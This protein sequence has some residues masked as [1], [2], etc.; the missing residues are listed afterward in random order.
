MAWTTMQFSTVNKQWQA[1]VRTWKEWLIQVFIVFSYCISL[2]NCCSG[3]DQWSWKTP[4]EQI[5]MTQTTGRCVLQLLNYFS[6][7]TSFND[8]VWSS[9]YI[10]TI[11]LMWQHVLIRESMMA[12][13]TW[14]VK[15]H[16]SFPYTIDLITLYEQAIG[17]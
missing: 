9:S 1:L 2:L 15:S 10:Y 8:S 3:I 7:H 4:L 16:L 5:E 14:N 12:A 6:L 17:K 13:K 11:W